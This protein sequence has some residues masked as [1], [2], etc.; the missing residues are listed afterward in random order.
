MVKEAEGEPE[1][2]PEKK[3]GKGKGKGK[4]PPEAETRNKKGKGKGKR[5]RQPVKKTEGDEEVAVGSSP[6]KRRKLLKPQMAQ[7]I[8]KRLAALRG[9]AAASSQDDDELGVDVLHEE[10][11]S[12]DA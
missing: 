3:K 5:R 1:V 12:Q 7:D 6:Q 9:Q 4:N 10:P 2:A 8:M 11:D